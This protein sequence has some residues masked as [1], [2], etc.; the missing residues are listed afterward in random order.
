MRGS[1]AR[2]G[3]KV[4]QIY[5]EVRKEETGAACKNRKAENT[6]KNGVTFLLTI[7]EHH[8]NI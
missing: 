7:Y 2:E 1:V 8:H 3:R 5:G 6:G 4:R